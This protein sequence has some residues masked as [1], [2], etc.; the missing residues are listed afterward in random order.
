M[1]FEL[2]QDLLYALSYDEAEMDLGLY[3]ITVQRKRETF[4]AW[5]TEHHLGKGLERNREDETRRHWLALMNV[6]ALEQPMWSSMPGSE[7]WGKGAKS[8]DFYS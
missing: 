6:I 3:D 4:A 5:R 1:Q 7:K 8:H 2:R